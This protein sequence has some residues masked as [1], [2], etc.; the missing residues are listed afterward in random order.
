MYYHYLN[1][2]IRENTLQSHH[3]INISFLLYIYEKLE[4]KTLRLNGLLTLYQARLIRVDPESKYSPLPDKGV[5]L[6]EVEW[7]LHLNINVLN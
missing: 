3:T 5:M 7:K 6:K 1:D 4:N 2:P